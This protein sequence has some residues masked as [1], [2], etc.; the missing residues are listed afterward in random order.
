[1]NYRTLFLLGNIAYCHSNG[2]FKGNILSVRY[3]AL[4][5]LAGETEHG[6]SPEYVYCTFSKSN[7]Y[8]M[9]SFAKHASF[10]S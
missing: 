2:S 8:S 6:G 4:D 5:I 7:Q 1:M 3:F 9:L 10:D